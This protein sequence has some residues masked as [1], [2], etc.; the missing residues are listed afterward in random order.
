MLWERL[1]LVSM[2]LQVNNAIV[3]LACDNLEIT[4]LACV[5]SD[6]SYNSFSFC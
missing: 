4:H 1:Y 6:L 3:K 5:N 2:L